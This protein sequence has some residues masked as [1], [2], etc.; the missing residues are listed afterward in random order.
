MDKA[1]D[2][3]SKVSDK[4]TQVAGGLADKAGPLADKAKPL[5][6][7]AAPLAEK[8]GSSTAAAVHSPQID[9]SI[10]RIITWL[11]GVWIPLVGSLLSSL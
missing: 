9:I 7:K 4:A 2:L 1:K 8:G 11:A 6:E 3:A 10:L 5:A